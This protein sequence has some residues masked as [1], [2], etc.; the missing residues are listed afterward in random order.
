[1]IHI[2]I[3]KQ[4]HILAKILHIFYNFL[5]Q[6][7]YC[8]QSKQENLSKY[9]RH[10][11]IM[12]RFIR[13]LLTL[14]RIHNRVFLLVWDP[15]YLWDFDLANSEWFKPKTSLLNH[16]TDI[17]PTHKNSFKEQIKLE[18]YETWSIICKYKYGKCTS[19][20]VTSCFLIINTGS[21]YCLIKNSYIYF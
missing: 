16:W 11:M 9:K 5:P 14:F 12:D 15:F 1:M 10:K 3:Q 20:W 19:N 4:I 21:K 8:I 6:F 17:I 7:S 18:F 13:I 2:T